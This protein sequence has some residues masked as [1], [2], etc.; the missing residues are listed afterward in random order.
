MCI[1]ITTVFI[2]NCLNV[3]YMGTQFVCVWV[4]G[5]VHS[6]AFIM[7]IHP[8]F[9]CSCCSQFR[10]EKARKLIVEVGS[11]LS[12]ITLT[13]DIMDMFGWL[14][15][16]VI[17]Q[18]M[19][20]HTEHLR[21]PSACMHTSLQCSVLSMWLMLQVTIT[22]LNVHVTRMGWANGICHAP[23]ITLLLEDCSWYPQLYN[24]IHTRGD[25]MHTYVL[26]NHTYIL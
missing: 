23:Q 10:A 16:I 7:T 13:T 9:I 11:F 1:I 2:L 15:C 18:C 24:Y 3:Q 4:C 21:T 5:C 20:P 26:Y 6:S 25:S 22:E 12:L 14:L 17:I 19:Y 8:N